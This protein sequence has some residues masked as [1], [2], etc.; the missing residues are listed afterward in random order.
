M[1]T[2]PLLVSTLLTCCGLGAL[3]FV[4]LSEV[5]GYGSESRTPALAAVLCLLVAALVLQ[6]VGLGRATA[7]FSMLRGL[8]HLSGASLALCSLLAGVVTAAAY[9]VMRSRDAS[10]GAL[11]VVAALSMLVGVLGAWLVGNQ[12]VIANRT[13]WNTWLVPACYAVNA[14]AMGATLL[15]SAMALRREPAGELRRVAVP[16]AAL[17]AVQLVTLVAYA[18]FVGW[19]AVSPAWYWAGAVA[20]GCLASL[21]AEVASLRAPWAMPVALLCTVAG[22]LCFR[23]AMRMLSSDFITAVHV[24]SSGVHGYGM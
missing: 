17:A 23:V 11:R 3:F 12:Y 19:G 10:R 1:T 8:S 24:V 9:L 22:G 2:L 5:Q 18:G 21:G 14:L 20:V 13:E 7:L 4:G 16:A 15:G 6:G